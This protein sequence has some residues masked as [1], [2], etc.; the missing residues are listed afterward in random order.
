MYQ[1]NTTPIRNRPGINSS[2]G[3]IV[4]CDSSENAGMT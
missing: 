1:P 3:L 4:F 2:I